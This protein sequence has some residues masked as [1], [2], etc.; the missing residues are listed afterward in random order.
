MDDGPVE[1]GTRF[2]S[3]K[4]G[5]VGVQMYEPEPERQRSV[6]CIGGS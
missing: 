1:G 2:G 6:V 5:L 3:R 4:L